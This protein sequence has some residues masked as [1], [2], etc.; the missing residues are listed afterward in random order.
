MAKT[1]TIDK[2][3]CIGCGLCSALA[4]AT[5]KMNDQN[6]A[7][8]L[9]PQGDEPQKI[10]ESIDSCPVSAITSSEV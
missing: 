10:Q 5:F 6:K 4:P 7:E 8:V 3:T 9:N 2:N 1:L